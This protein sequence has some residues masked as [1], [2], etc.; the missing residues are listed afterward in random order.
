MPPNWEIVYELVR[1]GKHEFTR[2]ASRRIVERDISFGEIREAI[3]NGEM[4]EDYPNDKHGPSCLISGLTNAG[5]LLHVQISYPPIVKVV[6]AYP[7]SPDEWETDN[8]TRK[9]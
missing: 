1:G 4:I 8:K 2:H 3:L 6:T 7:P 5:N 9:K